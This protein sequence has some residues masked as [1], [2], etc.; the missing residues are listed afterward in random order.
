MNKN[1]FVFSTLLF[2]AFSTAS[3][4]TSWQEGHYIDGSFDLPYQIYH[5]KSSEKLPLVI[6]LH[7]TGEAGTDNQAQLYKGQNVGPDYFASKEIQSIQKAIV[8]APQTPAEIRWASTSIEPYDFTTTPSTP[9]MTALL[10]LVDNLIKTDKEIDP[11]RIYMT[12][13]SRGGQGVW[14]AALQRPKFFAAIVPIAGSA[15]PKDAKR[16]IDL[17]IWAF[18]GDS[19]TTTNVNYTREMIDALIRSGGSTRT[20]RYTEVQGG[21]HP[22]SWLTAYKDA[23][24]YRWLISHHD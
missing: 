5:P 2:S 24:L 8:L 6:H 14:N 12:G 20:L 11:S 4:A 1:L 18:H 23:Q 13:L 10:H 19:D 7:G 21:E 22:D 16:L 15:S 9:S 3:W 17:P